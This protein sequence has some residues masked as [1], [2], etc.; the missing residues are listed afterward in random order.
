MRAACPATDMTQRDVTIVFTDIVDSTRLLT[1]LGE[2]GYLAA[3]R[4]HN[5]IIRRTALGHG[6]TLTKFLGDGWMI[7]FPE[8]PAAAAFAVD[9]QGALRCAR[10]A[11]PRDAVRVRI[12][13]HSGSALEEG[14]D[15]IGRDVVV[16]SRLVEAA[17]EDEIVASAP[18]RDALP[19]AAFGEERIT[20]LRGLGPQVVYRLV[21]EQADDLRR[22]TG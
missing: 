1:D 18:V 16:A 10:R 3:L 15:L 4:R 2:N 11:H 7:A 5:D 9:C 6:G 21:R 14:G 22:S 17:R 19:R 12:A 8:P 20:D 13:I